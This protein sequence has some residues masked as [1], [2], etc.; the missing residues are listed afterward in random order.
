MFMLKSHIDLVQFG[1]SF[2]LAREKKFVVRQRRIW[3]A[4][5]EGEGREAREMR[6][7]PSAGLA[8]R[9]EVQAGGSSSY[10][11]L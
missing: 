10:L 7:I 8:T 4:M 5:V 2:D 1:D 3:R 11:A 9:I 6:G